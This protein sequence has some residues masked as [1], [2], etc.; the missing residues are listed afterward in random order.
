[1]ATL[2]DDGQSWR[3]EPAC[4]AHPTGCPRPG[5]REPVRLVSVTRNEA[6]RWA[7][8]SEPRPVAPAEQ[9]PNR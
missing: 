3:H 2:G 6:P 5:D 7:P 4:R 1:M 8:Y 9:P